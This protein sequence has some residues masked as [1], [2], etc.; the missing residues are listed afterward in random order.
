MADLLDRMSHYMALDEGLGALSVFPSIWI[1]YLTTRIAGENTQVVSGPTFQ[2][3][4]EKDKT[5]EFIKA[6][7]N[8]PANTAG[9]AF[10]HDG[11][12]IALVDKDN[13]QYSPGKPF[14]MYLATPV[15]EQDYRSKEMKPGLAQSTVSDSRRAP[16]WRQKMGVYQEKFE[17]REMNQSELSSAMYSAIFGKAN[18]TQGPAPEGQ[19]RLPTEPPTNLTI[20]TFYIL[21]DEKRIQMAQVR[22]DWKTGRDTVEDALKKELQPAAIEKLLGAKVQ[23]L[24]D[25]LLHRVQRRK[26]DMDKLVDVDFTLAV[27]QAKKGQYDGSMSKLYDNLKYMKSAADAYMEALGAFKRLIEALNDVAKRPTDSRYHGSASSPT[28]K[29]YTALD[30]S[31]HWKDFD[32]VVERLKKEFNI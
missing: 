5:K 18:P 23:P 24:I 13:V 27:A 26:F 12:W 2:M 30:K 8:A 20:Q 28:G 4:P 14:H 1:K 7:E 11:D 9:I 22:A 10:K 17:R 29:S 16:K 32:S 15:K 6:V 3:K 31:Y 25:E 19:Y 21:R